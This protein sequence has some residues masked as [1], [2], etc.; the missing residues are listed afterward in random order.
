[1]IKSVYYAFM[2]SIELVDS[3]SEESEPTNMFEEFE[4]NMVREFEP[5]RMVEDVQLVRADTKPHEVLK[6]ADPVSLLD[7]T[8]LLLSL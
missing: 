5:T 8:L 4:P 1:M 3:E 6:A 2:F 7:L